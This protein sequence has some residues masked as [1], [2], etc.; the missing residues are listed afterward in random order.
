MR[1]W[2]ATLGM[3][4]A[5]VGCSRE[6]STTAAAAAP[7]AQPKL[8]IRPNGDTEFKPELTKIQ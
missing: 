2:L 6:P 3:L 4:V 7:P 8:G 5:V 1:R